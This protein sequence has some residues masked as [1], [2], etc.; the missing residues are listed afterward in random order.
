MLSPSPAHQDRTY[1]VVG[2]H[3]FAVT[4]S[5]FYFSLGRWRIRTDYSVG[6]MSDS[7]CSI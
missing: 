5:D 7:L 4:I 6:I 2:N 1:S 3:L